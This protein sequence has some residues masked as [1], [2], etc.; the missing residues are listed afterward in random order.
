MAAGHTPWHVQKLR[1][2]GSKAISS[3][4]SLLRARRFLLGTSW[5]TSHF[6]LSASHISILEAGGNGIILR[7]AN[8]GAYPRR[9]TVGGRGGYVSLINIQL[10][11][12]GLDV[13]FHSVIQDDVLK[14]WPD[15]IRA[16]LKFFHELSQNG[17]INFGCNF[18]I[19][20]YHQWSQLDTSLFSLMGD[21]QMFCWNPGKPHPQ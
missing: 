18:W 20:L 12:G 5:W 8:P 16:Y 14:C 13:Y 4:V 6:S 17:V 21:W 2:R 9:F 19:Q 1:G 3:H 11:R 7:P 15:R 10:G